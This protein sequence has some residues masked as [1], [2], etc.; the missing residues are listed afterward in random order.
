MDGQ[1]CCFSVQISI[2][3]YS[4]F[5]VQD[6]ST[7]LASTEDWKRAL[8]DRPIC[9]IRN[10]WSHNAQLGCFLDCAV[11]SLLA[12]RSF[13]RAIC[14]GPLNT[15]NINMLIILNYPHTYII[16]LLMPYKT[17]SRA[18]T[19]LWRIFYSW[20]TFFLI[21]CSITY[22]SKSTSFFQQ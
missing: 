1:W 17:N 22:L 5:T 13:L 16:C 9:T 10:W 7:Y 12:L 3:S 21:Y 2:E 8:I 4:L 14:P 6:I 11:T 20:S 15:K 19:K 18:Q